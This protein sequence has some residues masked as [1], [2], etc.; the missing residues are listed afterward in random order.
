MVKVRINSSIR[1]FL[2]AMAL[3]VA[4]FHLT[5]TKAEILTFENAVFDYIDKTF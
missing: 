4:W 3:V 5:Y 2:L 1:K